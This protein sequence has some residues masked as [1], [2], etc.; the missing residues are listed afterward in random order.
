MTLRFGQSHVLTVTKTEG[1]SCQLSAGSHA[2]LPRCHPHSTAMAHHCQFSNRDSLSCGIPLSPW[3]YLESLLDSQLTRT[4]PPKKHLSFLKCVP[5]NITTFQK[6]HQGHSFQ[7]GGHRYL[8]SACCALIPA[9]CLHLSSACIFFSRLEADIMS[10]GSWPAS[11]EDAL[12]LERESTLGTGPPHASLEQL[13]LQPWECMFPAN[14]QMHMRHFSP[15]AWTRHEIICVDN[16]YCE[17][18]KGGVER[19]IKKTKREENKHITST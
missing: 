9:Y 4:H 11:R 10:Q 14:F 8:I 5:L 3:N 17:G 1:T 18:G 19:K 12:K 6:W 2:Q 7:A 13:T 15:W 16:W